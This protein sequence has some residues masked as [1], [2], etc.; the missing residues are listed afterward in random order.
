MPKPHR[1]HPCPLRPGHPATI[2]S[3]SDAGNYIVTAQKKLYET[4]P[5]VHC[6]TNPVA[7]NDTANILLA[8]GGSA[9]MAECTAEAAEITAICHATLLNT[10]IPSDDKL[11]ACILAGKRANELGHPVVLD[12]VGVGA[13]TYRQNNIR[14]LLLH[15][16]PSL[17]R[18]N[19]EEALTLLSFAPDRDGSPGG[20]ATRQIPHGGVESGMDADLDARA[21]TAARLAGTYRTTVLLSGRADAVSDGSLTTLV[22]GGDARAA[23][24][25]GSGCMLSAICAALLPAAPNAYQAA[26]Y[27]SVFWKQAAFTAGQKTDARAAG[28]G[29]FRM[30]L[31]DAATNP[32]SMHSR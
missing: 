1:T 12:P 23:R 15:V 13:G 11:A 32:E 28:L 2:I 6:L 16:S 17:I 30:Y 9:I 31:F 10:G 26:L 27:A 20:A 29:S 24:I 14:K 21:D 3:A 25:T 7:M 8:V 4:A 19:L 18:C 5:R 22:T